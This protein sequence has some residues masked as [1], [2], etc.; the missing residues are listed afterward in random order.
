MYYDMELYRETL[1]KFSVM[2]K[3]INTFYSTFGGSLCHQV[4]HI[5]EIVFVSS[6]L[7]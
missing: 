2:Q 1:N 7:K 4:I 6:A 5:H 3:S